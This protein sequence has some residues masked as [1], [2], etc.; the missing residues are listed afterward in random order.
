MDLFSPCICSNTLVTIRP[1]VFLKKYFQPQSLIG[2]HK[3]FWHFWY[4]YRSL[5]PWIGLVY[6][7]I[8]YSQLTGKIFLA[9]YKCVLLFSS[10]T[11]FWRFLSACFDEIMD[12]RSR[13]DYEWSTSQERGSSELTQS[14]V[15]FIPQMSSSDNCL[16]SR[17]VLG[18][19][20]EVHPHRL[21]ALLGVQKR[22]HGN[23]P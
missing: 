19:F 3:V 7:K 15:V 21:N 4:I 8:L 12:Y 23:C 5:V 20:S 11:R 10:Y 6:F 9:Y 2:H 17:C 18:L 16:F 13:N 22:E 1:C 14:S